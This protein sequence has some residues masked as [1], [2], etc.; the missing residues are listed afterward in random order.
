[1]AWANGRVAQPFLTWFGLS[2]HAPPRAK[3]KILRERL[4]FLDEEIAKEQRSLSYITTLTDA[5]AITGAEIVRLT[6]QQLELERKWVSDP[7][8]THHNSKKERLVIRGAPVLRNS[9][10]A[11]D[12]EW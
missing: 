9:Q 10:I 11:T 5:R 1:M 6:I 2:I 8:D 4:R 7:C 12:P 3:I